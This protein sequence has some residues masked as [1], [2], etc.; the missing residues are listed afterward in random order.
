[1]LEHDD[2]DGAEEHIRR[3]LVI[4]GET[5][6]IQYRA[7][8][9]LF[10]GVTMRKRGAFAAATTHLTEA[11][12]LCRDGHPYGEAKTLIELGETARAQGNLAQAS[13][14]FETAIALYREMGAVRDVIESVERL[15][16]ILK[17]QNEAETIREHYEMAVTL[18][19]DAEFDVSVSIDEYWV[20]DDASD[21]DD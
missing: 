13:E 11:L 6:N 2:I 15:A 14:R 16:A 3:S 18:A 21:N 17:N 19:Q 20:V 12:S 8:G 7:M 5:E 10:L 4:W 9:R 1:M